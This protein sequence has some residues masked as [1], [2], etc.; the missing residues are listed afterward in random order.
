MDSATLV[1]TTVNAFDP[2]CH[3]VRAGEAARTAG[4]GGRSNGGERF[5]P[6]V[7]YQVVAAVRQ[8]LSGW[9]TATTT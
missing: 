8:R 2:Q 4:G 6:A 3:P 5:T 1:G 7:P 9:R